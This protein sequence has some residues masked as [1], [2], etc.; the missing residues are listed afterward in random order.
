L[1]DRKCEGDKYASSIPSYGHPTLFMVATWNSLHWTLSKL[2]ASYF[3]YGAILAEEMDLY[4]PPT[5]RLSLLVVSI[6][7]KLLMKNKHEYAPHEYTYNTI[8]HMFHTHK[9][10]KTHEITQITQ[11]ASAP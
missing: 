5:C 7:K 4:L 6:R 9:L 3:I 8:G 11:H 10:A 2:W 1:V